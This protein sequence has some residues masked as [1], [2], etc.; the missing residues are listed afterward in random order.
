MPSVGATNFSGGYAAAEHLIKLGHRR[1]GAIGGPEQLLCSRARIAGYRAALESAGLPTDR[2]LV[3]Y[4]N[5]QHSGGLRAAQQ[6]LALADPPTAIF[7]GSDQQATGVY[8][9][10]R[11]VGRQIPHDLSVVGFDDLHYAQWTAPP[12]TTIRQPLHEMGASAARLLLRLV[13]GEHLEAPASS[14]TPNSSSAT[15]PPR[16]ADADLHPAR[17]GRRVAVGVSKLRDM[18]S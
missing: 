11:L 15:A 9:A 8:E 5:F 17:P 3:R 13:N 14:S 18:C 7:A 2:D 6:L 12:L 4:G 1:I 16:C 10:A